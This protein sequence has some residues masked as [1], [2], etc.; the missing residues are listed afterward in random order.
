[1]H[2]LHKCAETP[3]SWVRHLAGDPSHTQVHV[4]VHL[5]PQHLQQCWEGSIPWHLSICGALSALLLLL[6]HLSCSP[7][8]CI[9]RS[10][11]TCIPRLR[12]PLLL[13][14]VLHDGLGCRGSQSVCCISTQL[15]AKLKGASARV[16][17]QAKASQHAQARLHYRPTYAD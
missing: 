11:C 3:H 13:L 15:A 14:G 17:I 10:H 2:L 4:S 16:K 1:M 12:L 7:L 6:L 8:C 9:S 5:H